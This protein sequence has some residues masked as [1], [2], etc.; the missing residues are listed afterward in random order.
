MTTIRVNTERPYDVHVGR[1]LGASVAAAVPAT[2]SKVAIFYAPAV[3]K[4]AEFIAHQISLPVVKLALADSEQAKTVEQ[5]QKCWDILGD[6]KFTRNDVI[7]SV[8][9]G[10]TT[11]VVGF[12]A[13]SWLR[14]I[15]V[16]HVPTT[17]LAMVDAAVGG[18][19]GINTAA[20]KNLVGAFHHPLAVFC[21]L[22]VLKVLPEQDVR[23]GF[24]EIIKCGFIADAN[25]LT[26]IEQFGTDILDTQHPAFEEV[27]VRAIA[28]KAEVVADDFTESK[29]GGLGREILNYGHT[30]GHAIERCENYSMRHGEAISIGMMFVAH[31]AN[32]AGVLSEHDVQR[33]RSLLQKLGLPTSY[34]RF[35]FDQLLDAM[36]IDKK[37]RGAVLRFVVLNGLQNPAILAGPSLDQ[38]HAAHLAVVNG[39]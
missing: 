8:G 14:G 20:G 4:F 21:D 33:H 36:A 18:K 10:A 35:D 6:E 26:A 16:I 27:V 5:L 3:E 25:I 30:Y 23:A 1:G 11:D 38:L 34:N 32:A 39:S 17:V 22:E 7:I 19:T 28:V 24:G 31:L 29:P 2:A 15:G 9:G 37:A 13:A 12:A